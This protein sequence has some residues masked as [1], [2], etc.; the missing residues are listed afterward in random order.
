MELCIGVSIVLLLVLL[1]LQIPTLCTIAIQTHTH[2]YT[3]EGYTRTHNQIMENELS[4]FR[5]HSLFSL[6]DFVRYA[7]NIFI[8][9]CFSTK[10]QFA[11]YITYSLFW[12]GESYGCQNNFFCTFLSKYDYFRRMECIAL[13]K[14]EANYHRY[15]V[16]S[17]CTRCFQTAHARSVMTLHNWIIKFFKFIFHQNN[18][19]KK[20]FKCNFQISTS[21]SSFKWVLDFPVILKQSF[22]NHIS[23]Y[24]LCIYKK[25]L[26][27]QSWFNRSRHSIYN[28]HKS[29]EFARRERG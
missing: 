14:R 27:A 9:R 20:Y 19:V 16:W 13:L 24:I 18:I 2:K 7:H 5:I 4:S 25:A 28:M 17:D 23:L 1:V 6:H 10:I 3:Y 8:Y 26:I 11:D 29:Y 22:Q 12:L 15:W 21:T